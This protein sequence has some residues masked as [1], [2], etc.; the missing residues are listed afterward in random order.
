LLARRR[1][2]LTAC[3]YALLVERRA[4]P[5]PDTPFLRYAMALINVGA[6]RHERVLIAAAA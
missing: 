4:S 3:R 5:L 6:C 1:A 2:P